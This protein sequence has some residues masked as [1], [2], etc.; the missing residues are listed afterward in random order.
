M[1]SKHFIVIMFKKNF[2]EFWIISEKVDF[3]QISE[4][5]SFKRVKSIQKNLKTFPD[6]LG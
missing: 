1:I 5:Q 2:N 6:C 3:S 4:S